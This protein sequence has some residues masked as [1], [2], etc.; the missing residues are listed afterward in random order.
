[1]KQEIGAV[2][3]QRAVALA[4][5]LFKRY[6]RDHPNP[7]G[8]IV[9]SSDNFLLRATEYDSKTATVGRL[10]VSRL[11]PIQHSIV[12]A[13]FRGK[14]PSARSWLP[15]KSIDAGWHAF[16]SKLHEGDITALLA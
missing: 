1:M 5:D 13:Q 6:L 15:K 4:T 7:Q 10:L 11:Q 14:P 9:W 3:I 2:G 8:R 12:I 16:R